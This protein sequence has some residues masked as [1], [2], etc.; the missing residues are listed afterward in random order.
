MKSN[1]NL[2]LALGAG[3]LGGLVS[4]Y[5]APVPVFA[6]TRPAPAPEPREIRAQSFVLTDD[7][8]EI[9]GTF[10]ASAPRLKEL[11]TVVLLDRWG[12]ET[13]R[14]KGAFIRPLGESFDR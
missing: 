8:G 11:P 2:V 5:E 6:Q 9:V 13:W 1:S 12:R 14:G 10:K 3:L 7:Q 4:R